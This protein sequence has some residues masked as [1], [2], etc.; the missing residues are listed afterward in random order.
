MLALVPLAATIL[1][2]CKASL[3]LGLDLFIRYE[4]RET[5]CRHM[6]VCRDQSN[7]VGI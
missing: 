1:A 4:A 7:M 5:L 6:T 2:T 3:F